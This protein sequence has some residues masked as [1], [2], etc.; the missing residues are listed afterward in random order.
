MN[1]IDRAIVLDEAKRYSDS[2]GG[3]TEPG[4]VIHDT[5]LFLDNAGDSVTKHTAAVN[6]IVL[7]L[8]KSY[9][10]TTDSGTFSAVAK[11]TAIEN[12]TLYYLGNIKLLGAEDTGESFLVISAFENEEYYVMCID[13]SGGSHMKVE[14]AETI[15]PI[16]PKFLPGAVLPV[17]ELTTVATAEGA[18][19]TDEEKALVDAVMAKSIPF[20]L[21]CKLYQGVE[22]CSVNAV[23]TTFRMACV[24]AA[25]VFYNG[26]SISIMEGIIQVSF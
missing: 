7:E 17:V 24:N 5:E 19:L 25:G 10:V 6:G 11:K 20:V 21:K 1:P 15:H 3:Y 13:Y 4:A 26:G 2:K 16:D 9:S 23:A 14:T 18:A 8:G 12:M 22:E